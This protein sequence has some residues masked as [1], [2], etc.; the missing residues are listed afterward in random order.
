MTIL[1]RVAERAEDID[2]ARAEAAS[3]A[4]KSGCAKPAV[5]HG[6]RARP[7]RAHQIADAA[8]GIRAVAWRARVGELKRMRDA[9]R[10]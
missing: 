10:G 6:L 2:I 4:P 5:R 9:A 7:R 3:G 1:A 8:A